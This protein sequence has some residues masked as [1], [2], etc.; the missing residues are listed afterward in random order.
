MMASPKAAAA[1]LR[2]LHEGGARV[3][4]D[5]FG[6]GF[7][8]LGELPG[9]PLDEIK[10]DRRF[11]NRAAN[12][13]GDDAVVRSVNELAHR[14]DS[15]TVAEGVQDTATADRM[16]DIGYDILQGFLYGMPLTERDHVAHHHV[17]ASGDPHRQHLDVAEESAWFRASRCY[18]LADTERAA[19]LDAL[20]R[21]T[22]GHG[23]SPAGAVAPSVPALPE[24]R[25]ALQPRPAHTGE[26]PTAS[27]DR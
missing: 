18:A 23:G 8:S 7:T 15:D 4:I 3:S 2:P 6:T 1:A 19:C 16:T 21:L 12:S 5:D 14:L 11:V 26:L 17:R 13:R 27:S 9:L 10:V 22:W 20:L 25:N 24:Q